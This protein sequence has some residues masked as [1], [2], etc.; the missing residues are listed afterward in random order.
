MRQTSTYA[1]CRGRKL[2]IYLRDAICCIFIAF[3]I[4]G[5]V[6]KYIVVGIFIVNENL[7]IL[8]KKVITVCK[9]VSL[10]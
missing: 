6:C 2:L 9:N 8:N 7:M 10:C 4:S 1:L 5:F 3:D